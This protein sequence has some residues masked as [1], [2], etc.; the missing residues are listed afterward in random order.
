MQISMNVAVVAPVLQECAERRGHDLGALR[1][2]QADRLGLDET[3]NVGRVELT[4]SHFS[5][6]EGVFEKAPNRIAIKA[7]RGRREPALVLQI[8]LE[9]LSYPTRWPH[10]LRIRRRRLR[11][12][13]PDEATQGEGLAASA[14]S[15]HPTLAEVLSRQRGREIPPFDS[16]LIEPNHEVLHQS[17][18]RL[19]RRGRVSLRAH[20]LGEDRHEYPQRA[21]AHRRWRVFERLGHDH[22]QSRHEAWLVMKLCRARLADCRLP[23]RAYASGSAFPETRHS[24]ADR[25]CAPH[26]GRRERPSPVPGAADRRYGG[27]ADHRAPGRDG[28]RGWR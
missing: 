4:K 24:A 14:A 9:L 6:A 15:M 21:L 13:E 20:L 8:P 10:L 27:P 25:G 1:V 3:N 22:L 7:D 2:M 17:D 11:R 16:P 18:R 23:R 19:H 5:R 12:S 26:R 28:G